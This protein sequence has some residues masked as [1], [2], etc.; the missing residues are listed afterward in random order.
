GPPRDVRI[1]HDA[2]NTH[3]EWHGRTNRVLHPEIRGH[4]CTRIRCLHQAAAG[5]ADILRIGRRSYE[6]RRQTHKP[7][8][9]SHDSHSSRP[10]LYSGNRNCANL[11][12]TIVAL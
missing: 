9:P 6:E 5:D 7:Y 12:F 8:S 4:L 10:T 11:D 3:I 1:D 2:H